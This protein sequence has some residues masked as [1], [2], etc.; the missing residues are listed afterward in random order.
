[1]D[2]QKVKEVVKEALEEHDRERGEKEKRDRRSNLISRA[3]T[4][5]VA[6][7]L[8][9]YVLTSL[10]DYVTDI[11]FSVWFVL[12][13]GVCLVIGV[14]I[15]NLRNFIQLIVLFILL[16]VAFNVHSLYKEIKGW[17]NWEY[18]GKEKFDDWRDKK[19]DLEEKI[20]GPF[21][22]RE[23]NQSQGR[24]IHSPIS[25]QPSSKTVPESSAH[26]SEYTLSP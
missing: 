4:T 25:F 2:E 8:C 3:V 26:F 24:R 9:W 19:E 13:V 5:I 17:K 1:M 22:K 14:I 18:P 10:L 12:S 23:D 6:L 11:V 16:V 15:G 7:A 21:L 20:K